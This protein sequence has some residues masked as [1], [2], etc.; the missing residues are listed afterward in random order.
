MNKNKFLTIRFPYSDEEIAAAVNA[1]GGKKNR[2]TLRKFLVGAMHSRMANAKQEMAY[3]VEATA[4][5]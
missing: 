4:N 5:A 3:P 2:E 1:I